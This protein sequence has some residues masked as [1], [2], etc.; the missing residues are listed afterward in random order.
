MKQTNWKDSF[1]KITTELVNEYE[2]HTYLLKSDKLNENQCQYFQN[3]LNRTTSVPELQ[4][5]ILKL[6]EFLFLHHGVKPIIL[7]DEYDTPINNSYSQRK[8]FFG[9]K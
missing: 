1:E 2:R 6:S 8:Y 9:F 5:S 4:D 3:I 7:I